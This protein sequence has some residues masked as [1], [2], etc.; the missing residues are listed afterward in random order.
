MTAI[1]TTPIVVTEPGIYDM[2]DSVYHRDPVPDGSLS[3]SEAG[4]LLDLPARYHH[5]KLVGGEEYKDTFDFGKA[6]H[7]L[8]LG[9]GASVEVIDADDWRTKA[10]KEARDAARA[11]GH[12]P[13]LAK[14]WAVVEAMAA[15]LRSHKLAMALLDP[16][17]GAPERSLFWLDHDVWRRAR[18][19][20][21]P[22]IPDTGRLIVPDYKTTATAADHRS[23]GKAA[24]SF[25]YHRQASW[26][27]DAVGEVL[28]VHDAAFVFIVQ[29]RTAPYLVNVIEL[30][31]SAMAI[32]AEQNRR[33]LDLY[34]E[35]RERGEWPAFGPG[36]EMAQLPRWAEIQHEEDT[37]Q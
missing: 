35:C 31:P 5:A 13:M 22:D 9:A 29:E 21:L 1:D 15:Q 12:T 19:D 32:G 3:C 16:T 24:A 30:A 23:F 7:R 18:L 8:V 27:L 2:P 36:V 10:A 11:D 33:A 28:D 26:Y 34:R 20:W 14:D 4:K 17:R 6:A 37:E 25:G